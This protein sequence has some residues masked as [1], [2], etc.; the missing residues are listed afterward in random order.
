MRWYL[1]PMNI[2]R[3]ARDIKSVASGGGPKSVRLNGIGSPRG[4]ILPRV[5]ISL[6]IVGR[7]GSRTS[8]EPELPIGLPLGY[9]YR[10][11]RSLHVP[12]I[13]DIDPE[14]MRAEVRVPGR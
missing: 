2:A 9:G 11:A 3:T 8:F 5:P 13:S 12:I 6:E 1:N 7:D 14:S 10:L 4:V